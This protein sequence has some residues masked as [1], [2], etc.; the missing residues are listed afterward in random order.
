LSPSISAGSSAK[1]WM[2][3]SGSNGIPT[4]FI[5]N[6]EGKVAWI[7]HPS[8]LE[9]PLAKVKKG[10]W[11]LA[12]EAKKYRTA[13]ESEAKV[14]PLKTQ[15]TQ[16]FK[17][18]DW[19]AA[20]TALDGLIEAEPKMAGQWATTKFHILLSEAQDYDRAYAFAGQAADTIIKDD[21]QALNSFAWTIV[22][23]DTSDDIEK[24]DLKVAL[25]LAKRADEVSKHQDAAILDTLARVYFVSGDTDKALETQK[26]AID[27]IE[28]TKNWPEDQRE[29]LR[30]ELQGRLDE[31]KEKAGKGGEKPKGDR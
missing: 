28:T 12:A 8:E 26:K 18:Q 29:T 19:D 15:L 2:A 31:Y 17:A 22:D 1:A 30:D 6:G 3:A 25:K 27:A 5:V 20:V 21:A 11:D 10:E 7:G 16:A 23:P 24:K 13:K 4:A 9:E 14:E